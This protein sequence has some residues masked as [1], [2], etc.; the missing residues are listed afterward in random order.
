MKGGALG[1]YT[2]LLADYLLSLLQSSNIPSM[3]SNGHD[4]EVVASRAT[5][6]LPLEDRHQNS[7]GLHYHQP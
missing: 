1:S 7:F 4:H 3:L 2:Y 6:V 5:R